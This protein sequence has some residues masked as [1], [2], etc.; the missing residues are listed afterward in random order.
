MT[1]AV[2]GRRKQGDLPMRLFRT[3]ITTI[4]LACGVAYPA[5]AQDAPT[6]SSIDI[7]LTSGLICDDVASVEA[8]ISTMNPGPPVFAPSCGAVKQGAEIPVTM[9][10]VEPFDGVVVV[11]F[12]SPDGSVQYGVA[13]TWP[14]ADYAPADTGTN[15]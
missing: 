8:T 12:T 7:V 11:K 14:P 13:R 1:Y 10:P 15:I 6:P 3:S 2:C 4:L 9:T 5:L